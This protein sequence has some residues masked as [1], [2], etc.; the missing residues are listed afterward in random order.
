MENNY[1]GWKNRATWNIALWLNNDPGLYQMTR[2]WAKEN[3]KESGKTYEDFIKE[4]ALTG[5]TPD[6][7]HWDSKD[8]DGEEIMSQ[9][10]W[11]D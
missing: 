10:V 6:R 8:I 3:P 11:G 4:N 9:V 1:N 5:S 2:D 7:V